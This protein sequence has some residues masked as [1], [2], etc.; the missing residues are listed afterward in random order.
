M[1][2]N[3]TIYILHLHTAEHFICSNKYYTVLY[4]NAF[5]IMTDLA[6]FVY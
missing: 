1:Q 4:V 6:N 2:I 3:E 5:N